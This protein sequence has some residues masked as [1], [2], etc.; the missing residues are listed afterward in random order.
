MLDDFWSKA[1]EDAFASKFFG[2]NA[3]IHIIFMVQ[4]KMNA[5]VDDDKVYICGIKVPYTC[6]LI[7]TLDTEQFGL[8]ALLL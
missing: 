3:T 6:V 4:K 2:V 8:L 7:P 1:F 5:F